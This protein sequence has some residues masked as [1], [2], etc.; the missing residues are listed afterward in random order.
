[1]KIYTSYF[2]NGAKLKKA[3]IQMIGIALFPPKWFGG[4]SIPYVAPTWSIL[5][6]SKGSEEYTLR[7]K[8]EV[9]AKRDPQTFLKM[10]EAMSQGKDVALCCFEK[11]GDFCHRHIVAEWMKETLGIE[12][13]EYEEKREKIV[14]QPTLF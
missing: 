6:N 14:E 11:P 10:I 5:H 8:S 3:G 7:F 13:S 2:A 12:V 9:L 4:S 1:M